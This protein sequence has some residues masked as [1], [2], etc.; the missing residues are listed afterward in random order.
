MESVLA[1]A[2]FRRFWCSRVL[3]TLAFQ[4]Q[5]V[6][7]GWQV[8][9]LTG[10]AFYLGS[11]LFWTKMVLFALVVLLEI[12]LML[13]LVRWRAILRKGG[14]P[15]TTGAR[16]LYIVSHIQMAIVVAMVFVASFMA[17]GF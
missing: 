10:S 15:D 14:R 8:Y 7:I 16:G 9:A 17:R 13:T 4:M 2:P 6:A 12:R 3:T 11:S 5:T 1:H